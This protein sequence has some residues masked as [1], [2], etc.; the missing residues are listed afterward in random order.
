MRLRGP[1]GL[2]LLAWS[3]PLRPSPPIFIRSWQAWGVVASVKTN[4]AP[5]ADLLTLFLPGYCAISPINLILS[6]FPNPGNSQGLE[7]GCRYYSLLS[8]RGSAIGSSINTREAPSRNKP[9][10]ATECFPP[11]A[12]MKSLKIVHPK[13]DLLFRTGNVASD[14]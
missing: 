3:H 2:G 10:F 13:E 1:Q 11:F 4:R 6:P 8:L 14:F 9:L 7:G 5:V 12:V